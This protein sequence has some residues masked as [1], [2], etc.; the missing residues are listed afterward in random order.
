MFEPYSRERLESL[1]SEFP[2]TAS[3]RAYIFDALAAPS[4]NVA[5]STRNVVSHLPNPKMGFRTQSESNTGERPFILAH[6]F[7]DNVIGF[8]TQPPRIELA[9]RGK[10]DRFVRTTYTPDCI[11]FA[12]GLGVV[13]EE[14]KPPSDRH[15][16]DDRYPGR[17]QNLHD[18]AFTSG[19]VNAVVNPMGIS[20]RLR[21]ADEI[22]EIGH[23][24]RQFLASY[25]HQSAAREYQ[26]R[27]ENL[28]SA[29]NG[30]PQAAIADLLD[31]GADRDVLYWAL[32]N[33]RL[34]FDFDAVALPAAADSVQVF[35]HETIL[36]AWSLS[37]RPNG[38]HPRCMPAEIERG[39]RQG[40]NFIFDGKR[41]TIEF[42][43]T[44]ALIAV[45]DDGQRSQLSFA[46]LAAARDKLV[47]P[48]KDA[49]SNVSPFYRA[50]VPA[51]ER[52]VRHAVFL[53]KLE[54]GELLPIG[55]QY[56]PATLRRWRRRVQEGQALGL[57]AVESLIDRIDSRGFRGPHIDAGLSK[58]I[59]ELIASKLRGNVLGK[60]KLAIYGDLKDELRAL[61]REMIA[62][63]TF[64]ERVRRHKNVESVR[65]SQGHKAAHAAEP[66]YWL[67]ER[68]TPIH[69]EQA[70]AWVHVDSTL[71]DIE[72]RS[73]ISGDTLGR[74]WLT[75]AVCS[76]TRR[77]L[78]F[79]LSFQPP[80][81][82]SSMMVLADIV[83]RHGRLPELVIHDWGSEFKA[84][85]YKHCL[86]AL[87]IE[88]MTRP[89][90]APRFGAVIERLFGLTMRELIDNIAGNTKLRKNVRMMSRSVDPREHSGV[91]LLELYLALEEFFFEQYDTRKHPAT[92]RTPRDA[93]ESSLANHGFRL[94]RLR[95]LEDI[96]PIL[97][98]TARGS[99]R[100]VDAV[101]GLYVN[102][103]NY[104]HPIL[105]ESSLHGQSV[106][107][108]PI[109]FDPGLIL[110]FL[111]GSW[112]ICRAS[113]QPEI[114]HAPEVVRRCLYEEWRV[115]QQ[116]VADSADHARDRLHELIQRLNAHA[117]ANREYWHDR[118]FKP[119]LNS[120]LF[121]DP[122][123]ASVESNSSRL[124][125]LT[126]S[127]V[128][129]SAAAL[130]SP[131]L[132]GLSS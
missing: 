128:R 99:V 129:A 49:A 73:S 92:L 94:H 71:L 21:F 89:K 46:T 90:S 70:M 74:P 102:Y 18:G 20:F 44:T 14:W 34:F 61:G 57:S 16:L 66:A 100:V 124:A 3:G 118:Q 58:R 48:A 85:D 36:R 42:L 11:V 35:L 62:K 59:D 82:V 93:Y 22:P 24:N 2:V 37:I 69:G 80:S 95:K 84:K 121:P 101:R 72:L 122:A 91:G 112:I 130:R 29:F 5:G 114:A 86:T 52:A 54:R 1:L 53:Q 78:G 32:A 17:Y 23:R 97:M 28:V 50:S 7:D 64:Y 106:T 81:Y 88:Q 19:P 65:A 77:I 39:L 51:L 38:T 6:T 41:L 47:M 120:T 4:R 109:P 96:L 63:S 123:T 12:R 9:Y 103:R 119:L 108:K 8:S 104:G 126:A 132:G 56:S 68:D 83:R 33:G 15:T 113:L 55:D 31:R 110:A 111:K 98:P 115:E 60:S 45:S 75:L 40:D 26:S 43:G 13:L 125:Q 117:L 27:S 105:S 10:N 131:E 30:L 76:F 107:V 116:L 87:A 67:L 127:M 79:H 25:L